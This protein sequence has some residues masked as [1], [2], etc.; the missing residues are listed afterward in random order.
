MEK[1]KRVPDKSRRRQSFSDLSIDDVRKNFNLKISRPNL[2]EMIETIEPS[3]WLRQVLEDGSEISVVSEKARSEFIVAPILLYI[4]ELHQGKISIYSGVRFDVEPEQGL[5]GICD[6]VLSKGPILPTIQ[7]PAF[8]MVEAKKNDIEEGLG[9]CSAE[10]VAAQ[11]FN[12]REGN[13]IPLIYGCVT[14][15][16]GWQFLRLVNDHL[17]IDKNR[18][19]IAQLQEILGILNIIVKGILQNA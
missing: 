3:S 1:Q 10:M 18:Y 4:R 11:I 2:F 8:L 12:R 9:Q 7:T 15:G 5:R 17:E 13:D 16:E 19:F 6:F 14:T